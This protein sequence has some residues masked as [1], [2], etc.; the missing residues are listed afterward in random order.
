MKNSI[1]Q[2]YGINSRMKYLWRSSFHRKV[3]FKVYLKLHFFTSY[4][5]NSYIVI[6]LSLQSASLYIS[7]ILSRIM[8]WN[9]ME[10]L[11]KG[12]AGDDDL[13]I[14]RKCT[15]KWFCVL[16]HYFPTRLGLIMSYQFLQGLSKW[17]WRIVTKNHK[18]NMFGSPEWNYFEL[19]F[20]LPSS[21]LPP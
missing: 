16:F 14:F 21:S 8:K 18:D 12:D 3:H 19:F 10:L 6:I 17:P 1:S 2:L 7:T 9:A 15:S 5:S 4:I 11:I 13:G 20:K